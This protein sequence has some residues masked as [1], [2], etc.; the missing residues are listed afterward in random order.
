MTYEPATTPLHFGLVGVDSSHAPAVT[1]LLG[2][3]VTGAVPGATITAAWKGEAARDFPPGRDRIDPLAREVAELGVPFCG[4]PE[5]VAERCDALLVVA[6]DARTHP[7][8]FTR[9]AVLGKPVYVD[10]RFALTT[11]EARDM[12]MAASAHGCLPLAGSPKRFTEEFRTALA[13]GPVDRIDL[14]G[15]LPTQPG[16]PVLD[17]Y[18]VH[19]VDLAVAALGPGCVGVDAP[20][21]GPATLSWADGRV[22]TRGGEEEWSPLT[23][24]RLEGPDGERHF[25]IEAGPPM[26]TGLLASIVDA[27]RS[28]VPNM[29]RAEMLE[30]VAVVEAARRSRASGTPV[31]PAA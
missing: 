18:G 15:P 26:L 6:S 27:C 28:G 25:T 7:G 17:W 20:E 11:R 23:T 13:G 5:E 30:I 21:G 14:T 19:L 12:L 29:P 4:T 9:L 22:A 3:G 16:H 2:G 10:T 31:T 8:L 1:R 24:G